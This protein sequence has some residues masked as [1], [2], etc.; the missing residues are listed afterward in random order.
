MSDNT[1]HINIIISGHVQGVGF[2]YSTLQA[3]GRTGVNGFV[4]NLPNGDV[5]IE[6]EGESANIHQFEAWC[7]KGSLY[8]SVEKVKIFK[9]EPKGFKTFSIIN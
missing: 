3:A 9:G 5:Y 8:A 1:V 2:R 6:A 4:K 7:H